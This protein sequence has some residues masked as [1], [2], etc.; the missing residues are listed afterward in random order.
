MSNFFTKKG[1]GRIYVMEE[2]DITK[3]E[4]IIKKIDA[5]EF[6][7]YYP[8]GLVTPF[9]NYPDIIYLHK[10]CDVDMNLVSALCWDSNIPIWVLDNGRNDWISNSIEQYKEKDFLDTYTGW[11]EQGY[12]VKKGQTKYGNN[13]EGQAV[14]HIDQVEEKND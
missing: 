8:K 13:S 6:E 2:C 14:F 12:N 10:F 4:T 7:G 9:S 3:V 5:S 11:Q 1:Y